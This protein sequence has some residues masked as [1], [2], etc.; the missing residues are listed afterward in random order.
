[1][2]SEGDTPLYP[3]T[4]RTTEPGSRS[5]EHFRE[6]DYRSKRVLK[7]L[8]QKEELEQQEIAELFDVSSSRI[9][10]L[11]QEHNLENYGPGWR[12]WF[13]LE[14]KD[15]YPAYRGDGKNIPIHSLVA[16]AHGADPYKVFG[17]PR[18]SV[19]HKNGH[20]IDNRPANVRLMTS[21][22]HGAK[23]GGRNPYTYTHSDLLAVI[24]YMLNP[25]IPKGHD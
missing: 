18:Y 19:D 17:N 6:F 20:K 1:M 12:G 10:R 25:S 2:S 4:L 11:I 3:S 23:D 14:N 22:A 16:I 21:S 5:L 9:C 15:G 7:R 24:S 8:Y 13:E